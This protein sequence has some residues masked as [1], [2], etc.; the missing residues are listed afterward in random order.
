MANTNITPASN[1]SSHHFTF[2]SLF[3]SFFRYAV[4]DDLPP[5]LL[6]A[7]LPGAVT[8]VL[9]RRPCLNP[10]LNP[11]ADLVG[12]RVPNHSLSRNLAL[13]AGEALA[14]TSANISSEPSCLSAQVRG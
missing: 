10:E 7:L 4:C 13:A 5:S 11:D 3:L 6:S 1:S 9:R 8:V 2:F 14:L 12:V